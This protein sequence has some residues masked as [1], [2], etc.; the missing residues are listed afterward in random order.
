MKKIL[1]ITLIILTSSCTVL[2][3]LSQKEEKI[4]LKEAEPIKISIDE[5]ELP[6]EYM[7]SFDDGLAENLNEFVYTEELY[8]DDAIAIAALWMLAVR[9]YNVDNSWYLSYFAT[10]LDNDFFN[11][12]KGR[13]GELKETTKTKLNSYLKNTNFSNYKLSCW[14]KQYSLNFCLWMAIVDGVNTGEFIVR[15]RDKNFKYKTLVLNNTKNG[16]KVIDFL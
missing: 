7:I 8:K 10:I 6:N 4:F 14:Q 12:N 5:G 11:Y 15:I 16:Y 1:Y 2:N 9:E 13:K 3:T